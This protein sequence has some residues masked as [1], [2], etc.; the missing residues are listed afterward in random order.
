M[1]L[2]ALIFKGLS[3]TYFC[4]LKNRTAAVAVVASCQLMTEAMLWKLINAASTLIQEIKNNNKQ[5]RCTQV[6][7]KGLE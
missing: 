5:A 1:A 6:P 3:Y 7:S 4:L 2:A